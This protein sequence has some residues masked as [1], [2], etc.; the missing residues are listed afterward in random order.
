[1]ICDKLGL[2]VS[3]ENPPDFLK[4]ELQLVK[5]YSVYSQKEHFLK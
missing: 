3:D 5:E 2:T 1:M 4:I